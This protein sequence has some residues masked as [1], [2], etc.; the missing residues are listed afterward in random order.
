MAHVTSHT[1][2]SIHICTDAQ[3]HVTLGPGTNDL[4]LANG[5][6]SS[7]FPGLQMYSWN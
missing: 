6:L 1:H 7:Y 4:S 5:L 2:A 3:S